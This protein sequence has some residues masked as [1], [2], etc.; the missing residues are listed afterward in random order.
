MAR[1]KKA[2]LASFKFI[3][4]DTKAGRG[5]ILFMHDLCVGEDEAKAAKPVLPADLSSTAVFLAQGTNGQLKA[6]EISHKEF[7]DMMASSAFVREGQIGIVDRL[8][9]LITTLPQAKL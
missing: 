2:N 5:G 8:K 9:H 4:L 3:F 1:A 7:V 6:V